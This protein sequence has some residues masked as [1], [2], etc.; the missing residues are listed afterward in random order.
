MN[1]ALG[2][3]LKYILMWTRQ[4][5]L[6]IINFV[7]GWECPSVHYH[8]PLCVH[9]QMPLCV[10]SQMPLCACERW[11]ETSEEQ[12]MMTNLWLLPQIQHR[13]DRENRRNKHRQKQSQETRWDKSRKKIKTF[14]IQCPCVVASWRLP[15]PTW[16]DVA[17]FSK[18]KGISCTGYR[19]KYGPSIY[20]FHSGGA[21][22]GPRTV[23]YKT[24]IG[25][26]LNLDS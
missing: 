18:S 24:N 25:N 19:R 5:T 26:N 4:K 21:F 17:Q 7:K 22:H 13:D 6:I 10:H 16:R 20:T 14:C 3:K 23:A 1:H 9:Y 11:R 2:H 15:E 8:M 12:Q